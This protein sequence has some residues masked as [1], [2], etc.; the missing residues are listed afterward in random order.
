MMAEP[1]KVLE[2]NGKTVD[3]AVQRA[4]RE[5]GLPRSQVEVT[6]LSEGRTGI[7]GIGATSARVRVTPIGAGGGAQEPTAEG[8]PLP[9]IDDYADAQEVDSPPPRQQ[10]RG[11]RGRGRRGGRQGD[12]GGSR[13]R[14]DERPP[15]RLP[16]RYTQPFELLADPEFEPEDEP[17]QHAAN[18]LTDLLHLIGVEATVSSREPATP[19][20]GLDHATAVLDVTPASPD[21]DLG[22]L[23]GRR[24]EHL[25][26]LQYIVNLVVNQG[27]EGNYTFTLDVDGFKRRRE[28][29]L[30]ALARRSA[31]S[32]RSTRETVAL[33]P[34]TPAER[35][36]VHIALAEDPDVRSE[37]A[38]EGDAR[39]VQIVYRGDR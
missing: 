12:R 24:G 20:D 11:G 32:V 37:S 23:I 29:S 36:I 9:R 25:A 33:E 31:D 16:Q 4:L 15:E 10:N 1:N 18:V 8:R 14:R 28:E 13:G 17:T 34:M 7:F 35:R 2:L 21:D 3:G 27:L 22:L 6:V 39:A 30:N 5:L 38:G 19:M 26:A